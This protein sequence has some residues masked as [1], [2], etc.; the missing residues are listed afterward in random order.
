MN[1]ELSPERRATRSKRAHNRKRIGLILLGISI[2]VVVASYFITEAFVVFPGII[3]AVAVI[4]YF[5]G[6]WELR[7]LEK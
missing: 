3:L 6:W 1:S 2:V 5:A 4:Y 7:E